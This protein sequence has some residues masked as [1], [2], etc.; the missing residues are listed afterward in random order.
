MQKISFFTILFLIHSLASGQNL[1]LGGYLKARMQ[2]IGLDSTFVGH[3]ETFRLEAKRSIGEKAEFETHLLFSNAFEAI[4]PSAN[5]KPNSFMQNA[6]DDLLGDALGGIDLGDSTLETDGL[7]DSPIFQ[8]LYYSSYVPKDQFSLDRAVLKLYFRKADLYIGKQVI[9]WGTG[10]AWNP[11]DFWNLKNPADPNAP[12]QGIT[13]L[14]LEVPLGTLSSLDLVLAPGL[15]L[16]EGSAGIRLKSNLWDFDYSFMTARQMNPDRLLYNLPP[17]W[18]TGFDLAGD[19]GDG[20]GIW[21]ELAYN[22]RIFSGQDLFNTDSNYFNVDAGANYTFDNGLMTIVEFYYNGL[23]QES[24]SNYSSRDFNN[25]FS[26]EVVGIG[27]Y[28]S[29]ISLNK[30]LW[31]FYTFNLAG[32]SNLSDMS[33]TVIP[34]LKYSWHDDL[35]ITLGTNIFLGDLDSEF[36]SL[37]QIVYGEVIGYF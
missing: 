32:I 17:K 7:L 35:A 37:K 2:A 30:E 16:D 10:Y 8:N 25:L 5:F 29:L 1:E 36:G 3:T 12:K 23:G 22:N 19:V 18:I 21:V 15:G 28:Y 24:S 11:T 6:S 26:G 34:S 33:F 14:R 9:A 4:D 13:A 20:I 27:R 31:D